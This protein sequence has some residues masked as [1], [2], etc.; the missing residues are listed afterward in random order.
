MSEASD[1]VAAPPGVPPRRVRWISLLALL[2]AG[3]AIV[4]AL[5]NML[6]LI[7]RIIEADG[8]TAVQFAVARP[9]ADWWLAACAAACAFGLVGYLRSGRTSFWRVL[10]AAFAFLSAAAL[11]FSLVGTGDPLRRGPVAVT[12]DQARAA[13][14]RMHTRAEAQAWIRAM[15]LPAGS[16][17]ESGRELWLLPS[18]QRIDLS[19]TGCTVYF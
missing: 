16:D 14:A 18:G 9:I 5:G 3:G 4:V 12:D 10:F 8:S 1:P 15:R 17:E 13:C 2:A 6:G 7:W 19:D 11:V